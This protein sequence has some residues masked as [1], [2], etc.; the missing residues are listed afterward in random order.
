MKIKLDHSYP[1]LENGQRKLDIKGDPITVF[2]YRIVKYTKEELDRYLKIQE[3]NEVKTVKD[4][5]GYI[6][7]TPNPVG[8]E[9]ELK[10]STN[11]KIYPDTT[12]LDLANAMIKNHGRAGLAMA[13]SILNTPIES[14][15]ETAADPSKID[16][17]D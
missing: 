9:G 14:V 7:F 16:A 13:Q 12:N 5:K 11:D 3:A 4:E 10:I 2:V 17:L 15:E 8:V 1:K 6:W